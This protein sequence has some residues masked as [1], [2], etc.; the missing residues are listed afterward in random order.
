MARHIDA[1]AL[2]C[3]K[4]WEG[5]RLAAYQ[6]VA[7]VWTIG[8]GHTGSVSE[9]MTVTEAEADTLLRTDLSACEATVERAVTVP[10]SD[11]QF[12]ALVS[13]VFNVG[14]GAFLGSTLL[15][16]LNAGDYAAVPAELA[17][18]N[19]ARDPRTGQLVP[20]P[21]LTNRRAAEAGLWARGDFVHGNTAAVEAPLDP[22]PIYRTPQGIGAGATGIGAAGVV[23]QSTAQ[24]L[25]VTGAG[26]TAITVLVVLLIVVGMGLTVYG[27]LRQAK[28]AQP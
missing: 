15:R 6:D 8:Y 9:G 23:M 24:S 22:A 4:R 26:S 2:D 10:L 11:G 12:G 18:W 13:F 20:V 17:R 1:Y 5:L 16:R 19:K 14:A 25:Q 28:V 7:G 3:I 27:L 21:G